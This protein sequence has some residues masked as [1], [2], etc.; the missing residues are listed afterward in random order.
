[1]KKS[2]FILL[3]SLT[4]TL[5]SYAQTEK[6][7]TKAGE[8][9]FIEGDYYEAIAYYKEA[10]KFN[11]NNQQALQ[12]I[13][14]SYYE[15]KDYEN[16]EGF[17]N[18]IEANEDFP[19]LGYYTAN[20]FKLIGKYKEAKTAFQNFNNAYPNADFYKDKSQQEVASCSWAM[21]QEVDPEVIIT[22][23]KKPLNTGF[24]DFGAGYLDSNVIQLSSLQTSRK[25][26]K[27]DFQAKMYVFDIDGSSAS[28]STSFNIPQ[29]GTDS[30][31]FANGYYLEE[32]Q[33]FYFSKCVSTE[34]GENLCDL[35]VMK[36][37]GTAWTQAQALSINTAN[38]TETQAQASL[39]GLGRTVL[40]FV[41][42]RA[43]GQGKLDIW[44][45]TE[46]T[47][48]AFGE[49]ENLGHT[50]NT[51]ANESTPF[52]DPTSKTLYFS[53]EWHYGFG[54]YDILAS[55]VNGNTFDSPKNLG[56]PINSSA[57]DQYYYP[58]KFNQALFASNRKGALQL[59]GSACCY[60]VFAHEMPPELLRIDTPLLLTS[61][62]PGTK[63]LTQLETYIESLEEQLPATVFFH[64][65]EPNPKTNST[66][67][68]LSYAEC[69][70]DYK[71]QKGEYFAQFGDNQAIGYWFNT[72]DLAYEELQSFLETLYV[73][74]ESRQ[75][76]LTIEG[77]CSPL[78]LNDYNINL[79]K[80]RI[81]SLENYILTWN[82]GQ[83]KPYY[84]AGE[85]TFS[86]VPFGE[87][88]A[89]QTI[90]DSVEE[91]KHS[92]YDPRAAQERRVE[93]IA[94]SVE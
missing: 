11:K 13:A 84:D 51:I 52:F 59:R 3:L 23:F 92:I 28:K 76:D 32:K 48:G 19:L 70:T 34:N 87:E 17:F 83:L 94:I 42:D 73:V 5:K 27:D 25:N 24:S 30:F 85:L 18:K 22:Q 50:I 39:N 41:S 33:S 69:Y 64:N 14:L 58:S 37:K 9:A 86:A 80:R 77:Y 66:K 44:R 93:I 53:S 12:K 65:D 63:D 71:D 2:I 15:L 46:G 78:A 55:Q 47:N 16:A 67:T 31:D 40:Y 20:N 74:L 56:L 10:L 7:F 29:I 4:C 89:D 8:S 49:A 61:I 75:V 90:S 88:K 26:M 72:V 81:V 57:N 54:A 21:D 43:G 1:M 79:A 35:Y 6:Q 36:R 82:E 91:V 45:A 68:K 62:D 38:Y 60:D